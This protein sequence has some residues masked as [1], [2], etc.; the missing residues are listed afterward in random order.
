M[1]RG[2]FT[3]LAR[4]DDSAPPVGRKGVGKSLIIADHLPRSG[5]TVAENRGSMAA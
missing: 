2:R 3:A 4:A 1:H 5:V